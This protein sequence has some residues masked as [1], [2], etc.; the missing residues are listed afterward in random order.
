MAQ[1]QIFKTTALP[2]AAA[3]V[4]NAIYLVGPAAN[5]TELEIYVV[6]NAGDAT[7]KTLSEADVQTLIDASLSGISAVEVVADIAERDALTLT[8][9]TMIVVQD[10]SA[11]ST[12]NAGA[13]LYVYKSATSN[14]A[15]LAE[16]ES[17]DVILQWD[18][19]QGRPTSSVA[20][21][22]SAVNQRHTHA[23]KTELDK[24]GEDASQCPTYDGTNFVMAGAVAW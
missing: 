21:I 12:V 2:A 24:L 14:F 9:N 18:N 19:I 15:K 13:A 23:N 16:F 6:N 7:R 10:A 11:D 4:A 8:S 22:D 1:I 17:L 20:D 3:L 5:A